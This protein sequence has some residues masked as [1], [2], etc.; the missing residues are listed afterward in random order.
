MTR[1]A[2]FVLNFLTLHLDG[3]LR[4]SGLR[5]KLDQASFAFNS[6]WLCTRQL[7]TLDKELWVAR[8]A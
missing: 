3:M 5:T 8:A 1:L 4:L 7:A 6:R 2:T